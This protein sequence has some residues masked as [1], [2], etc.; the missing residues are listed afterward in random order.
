MILSSG[1]AALIPFPAIAASNVTLAWNSSTGTNIAGYKIYYGAASGTYTNTVDVGNVTNATISSLISGT[2]YYF[3]ATAYD[4]FAL[5]SDYSTEA[6]FTNVTAASPAI[7][8]SSPVSGASYAAPAA[9]NLAASVTA[10]GHTITKVQFYNGANLLAED[11]AAPYTFAWTSVGAGSYSLTAQAVYDSGSTVASTPANVTV[12]NVTLPSIALTAPANGA[13]YAAPATINLAAN[14]AA[15]GHTITKV[16]FYN[17]NTLLA[18]DAAAPYTLAWTS[19]SAGSYSLRAQ[20]V[21]DSGGTVA[22]SPAYVAVTNVTSPSVALTAPANGSAYTAP[23]TVNLAAAVTANGHTIT[24]VQFYNGAT[25]LAE[26]TAAPYSIAWTNVSAGNYSLIAQAVYDSGSTVA[27]AAANVTLTNPLP[28]IVVAAPV[29]GSSYAAPATINLIASVTANGHS[30]TKV[31]FYNGATL[32]AEDT[33][34]PYTFAWASVGIGSYSLTARAVYDSGST[35]ASAPA[36]VTVTSATPPSIA[37]TA[38][39]NG[40]SY[41]AHATI[42]LAAAVTANSHT[43]TKVQ[44]YNGAA[45]LGENASAPYS[46]AWANVSA[47]SY[48]LTAQAVYDSGSVAASAAANVTVTNVPLPSIALTAPANGASYAAPATIGL[49]ATVNANGHTI[50][51]VQFYNGAAL[52]AEDSAAPYTFTWTSVSAGNYSLTAQVIYDSGSAV[53]SAPAN[54][55][56][57]VSRPGNTPPIISAITDHTMTTASAPLSIP[58]TVNDAETAASSLTVYASSTSL[59]LLPTNNIVFGGSDSNRTVTLTPIS[60]QTGEADIT[61]IVSDGSLIASTNFHLTV[62]AGTRTVATVALV[63]PSGSLPTASTLR[64]DWK[65]DP[66]ATW[67]ELYIASNGRVFCDKW[68]ASTNLLVDRVTGT[69]AVDVA[70]HAAG[71]YQW[72]IRGWS[73][74]GFG[75]WSSAG[76]FSVALPGPVTLLAPTNQVSMKARRP[77]LS[78]S[79]STP[80][81]AWYRLWI[82]RN[83]SKCLEQW[84]EGTTNWNSAAELAGGTYT[85]AVQTWNSAGLGAWSQLGTFTIQTIVPSQV[86]LVSPTG[87]LAAG[88][89]QR[90]VWKIDS[91]ATWYELYGVRNGRLFC[92][93]WFTSSNSVVD[94]ATGNFAVDVV[95]HDGGTYQWYVRGWSPDGLGPWSSAGSF[96]VAIPGPVTLLTPTNSASIQD[97]RP[98]FAWSQSTPAA[99]WC[100]LYVNRNGSKY[101]DQWIEGATNW[102]PTADLPGGTYSWAVQTWNPAGMGVWSQ[103][104]TFTNQFNLP[105]TP[106]LVSPAGNV[107]VSPTQRYTWQADPSATW[108][109]LYITRNGGLFL[110]QWY[111]STNSLVDI[112]TDNFA[113]DVSG[114]GPGNYQ[115]WVR[116]WSADGLG[117]WSGGL[118]FRE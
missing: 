25:L 4:T 45:L 52:L 70:G 39:A 85:W 80:A 64:Y 34:A 53:A 42:N 24:K 105:A 18:E 82:N 113:V 95:G 28:S 5:E 7:V 92:D 44:F 26:D 11:T 107:N 16:Q 58:F 78:W 35:V 97:R 21:Y 102:T 10:N 90:Y 27:S 56:V 99:T 110:N 17:G 14:V 104:A 57:A 61:I 112:A 46:F 51:K 29:N 20:A 1:L 106:V 67:Y 79:A 22:S 59:S 9:V 94:S 3:A 93:K 54:V 74:N 96:T 86:A 41:A 37:L 2:T 109:E 65:A 77:Q 49:A 48:S 84:I 68:Y 47:G 6:I 87:N 98:E 33:S 75:P 69:L 101:L 60:G 88:S 36:N 62:S 38:P 108:Y 83:G 103:L 23:A 13:S 111:A 73:P 91:A 63:S 81:A 72:Y 100:Y 30:I 55:T 71:T 114:H 43:I 118:Y 12:T 50:T 89:T 32:L 19:V 117:S 40:A 8:L 76:G 31:Q 66:N 116:G 15:N 115:W